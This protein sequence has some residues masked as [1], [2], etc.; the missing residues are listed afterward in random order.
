LTKIAKKRKIIIMGT[1]TFNAGRSSTRTVQPRSWAV[2]NE[3]GTNP[4]ANKPE[5]QPED[6]RKLL[7]SVLDGLDS[8]YEKLNRL[9]NIIE[10]KNIEQGH[11]KNKGGTK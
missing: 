3:A 1:D 2:L 11:I 7:L 5:P 9:C 4:A 8:L 6:N 10:R